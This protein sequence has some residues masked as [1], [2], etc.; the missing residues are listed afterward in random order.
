M[1]H[2]AVRIVRFCVTICA[3]QHAFSGF[4]F[5]ELPSPVR[6][7][8]YIKLKLLFCRVW[9]VELKSSIV[10][11][12]TAMLTFTP[13]LANQFQFPLTPTKLLCLI[14]LIAIIGVGVL[15]VKGAEFS[16]PVAQ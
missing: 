9:V 11:L 1:L 3:Q 10:L 4:H 14:G 15:A 12:V 8:T 2:A 16:L 7:R 13:F 6:E 5:H